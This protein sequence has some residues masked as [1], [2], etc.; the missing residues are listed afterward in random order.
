MIEAI[1]LTKTQK[2]QLKEVYSISKKDFFDKLEILKQTAD[3][4][5]IVNLLL[6]TNGIS[7]RESKVLD[8]IT[9]KNLSKLISKGLISN[10]MNREE[11][12]DVVKQYKSKLHHLI[13]YVDAISRKSHLQLSLIPT[14]GATLYISDDG[15]MASLAFGKYY[16][17]KTITAQDWKVILDSIHSD[18]DLDG[19]EVFYNRISDWIDGLSEQQEIQ[20]YSLADVI[21]NTNSME[22]YGETTIPYEINKY[23]VTQHI[24]DQQNANLQPNPWIAHNFY[25]APV[26]AEDLYDTEFCGD[27][28]LEE[29]F[30][31]V[32][33]IG[34]EPNTQADR[35][36]RNYARNSKKA[37]FDVPFYTTKGALLKVNKFEDIIGFNQYFDNYAKHEN[38]IYGKWWYDTYMKLVTEVSSQSMIDHISLIEIIKEEGWDSIRL[39]LKTT[40]DKLG[41]TSS[42][43]SWDDLTPFKDDFAMYISFVILGLHKLYPTSLSRA[44]NTNIK[45]I[46]DKL[47]NEIKNNLTT[48]L[49]K[50]FKENDGYRNWE[51]RLDNVW[52]P[53]IKEVHNQLTGKKKSES[54]FDKEVNHQKDFIKRIISNN[55][56][57]S[58]YYAYCH[59]NSELVKIDFNETKKTFHGLHCVPR[60]F[61]GTAE[62][63]VIW[64]LMGDNE[65]SWKYKNLN[66][67][68]DTPADYWYSLAN[69]N[70]EMLD[71]NSDSLSSLQKD[72]VKKFIE[73]CEQ[74][75]INELNYLKKI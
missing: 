54:V 48:D 17:E 4:E 26:K 42:V 20:K 31:K 15:T 14:K 45:K 8:K 56:W 71:I 68:F 60:D 50:T 7:K 69:R 29:Y 75:A 13:R 51:A 41:I 21:K 59:T 49:L 44:E 33:G 65:G 18:Y 46:K 11:E 32:I 5:E 30:S 10:K 40:K 64:G 3:L 47:I 70:K 72:F 73:L 62:D 37:L 25:K 2:R 23:T 19:T 53:A 39:H 9:F 28:L 63:G 36:F 52:T 74:I 12:L 34:T 58:V 43:G 24:K 66:E 16:L 38:N 35:L 22:Y 27:A 6:N 57:G 55:G 67:E 61:G 1:P